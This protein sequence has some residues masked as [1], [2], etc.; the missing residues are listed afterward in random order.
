M[1]QEESSTKAEIIQWYRWSLDKLLNLLDRVTDEQF[2]WRLYPTSHSIAY[3]VWHL[4]RWADH[5]QSR[6]YSMTPELFQLFGEPMEIW[7]T[8]QIGE[9]WGF[10][11]GQLGHDQTGMEMDDSTA[12]SLSFDREELM[13]Y[14]RRAFARA[15]D[16]V[17]RVPESQ[18]ALINQ[19]DPTLT[20]LGV[21]FSHFSH[22]CRHLGMIEATLGMQ[23]TKGTATR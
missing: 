6:F 18:Y 15:L 2:F 13:E 17:S 21:I 7:I 20:V 23:G 8:E 22:N 16:Y 9:K 12:A 3:E 14:T 19:H 5:L 11:A 4:A 1:I 10:T